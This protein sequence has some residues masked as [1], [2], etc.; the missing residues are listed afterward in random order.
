MIFYHV[1]YYWKLK[2]INNYLNIILSIIIMFDKNIIKNALSDRLQEI[3]SIVDELIPNDYINELINKYST[4]L[5]FYTY[6]DSVGLFSTLPLKGSMRYINR[7]DKQLRYGGLLI[8][9][10]KKN[11]KWYGIIKLPDGKKNYISFNA[12]YIF[13]CENQKDKNNK[14]FNNALSVFLTDVDKGKYILI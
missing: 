1:W 11:N 9:I 8:K 4:E 6:I 2:I 5:E 12:N 14:N 10:Y 13:Y 7:Y 3:D